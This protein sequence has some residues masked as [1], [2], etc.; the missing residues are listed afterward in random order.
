MR[1]RLR[2]ASDPEEPS[3][4]LRGRVPMAAL[5]QTLAVAEYLSFHRAAQAL[6]TSQSS[7]SA[8]VKA[9]EEELGVLLFQR[10]TRGVRLTE[11]GRSFVTQVGGALETLDRAV[12][13]AG[14][15]ARDEHG[16]L[17]ILAAGGFLDQLLRSFRGLH[18]RVSLHITE[19]TARDAQMQVREDLLDIAFMAGI[20]KIPDLN[21]R[22]VWRD[23]LMVAMAETHPFVQRDRIEWKDLAP[24]TFL[25]RQGGTGPQVHDLLTVRAVGKWPLPLIERFNVGRDALLAMIGAGQG[26]SLFAGENLELMPSGV[27]AREIADEPETIPFS[28]VW[29]PRNQSQTVRN[30]LDLA[31]RMG[32]ESDQSAAD[33]A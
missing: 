4:L 20:H 13:T 32:R 1:R 31:S 25:V 3:Q 12:K 16:S 9:L 10:N 24:E 26:L 22:V 6:G 11:A 30:L 7:V 23:R 19:G 2:K 18:A 8:R 15:A 21:S 28:V 27:V 29:S 17:R 14:M 5:V 33:M